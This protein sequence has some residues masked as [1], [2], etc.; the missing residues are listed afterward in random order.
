MS[1]PC[2]RLLSVSI[3]NAPIASLVPFP[4][5]KP[6]WSSPIHSSFSALLCNLLSVLLILLWMHVLAGLWFCGLHIPLHSVSSLSVPL[7]S[8]R[9]PLA[10]LLCCIYPC[11]F[12]LALS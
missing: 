7:W 6:Y 10:T 2:C 5:L 1:C 9:N 8:A 12:V 11:I 3:L 4:F